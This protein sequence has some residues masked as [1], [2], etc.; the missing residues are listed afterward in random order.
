MCEA[1]DNGRFAYTWLADEHGI[2]FLAAAENLGQTFDFGFAANDGVEASFFGG[3]CHV[4]AEFIEHRCVGVTLGACRCLAFGS[5]LRVARRGV[6]SF[7]FV[8][9]SFGD[10]SVGERHYVGFHLT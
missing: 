9:R 7:V 5:W 10:G 3:A 4:V 6:V 1:F 2:V 8:A